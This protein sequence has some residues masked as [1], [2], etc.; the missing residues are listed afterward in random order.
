MVQQSLTDWKDKAPPTHVEGEA[1]SCDYHC[2][3]NDKPDDRE[4]PQNES[5]HETDNIE[6]IS[7]GPRTGYMPKSVD[8]RKKLF[9]QFA[10]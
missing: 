2:N 8:G 7:R 6:G 3:G 10:E 5:E 1:A 4:A 9:G